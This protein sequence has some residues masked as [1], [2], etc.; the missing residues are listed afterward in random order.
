MRSSADCCATWRLRRPHRRK[1]SA[2]SEPPRRCSRS[3]SPLTDLVSTPDRALPKIAGIGPAS[4]RVILEVLETG[5]SATVEQAVAAS[6]RERRHPAAPRL[7]RQ[8]PE[9]GGG[10]ADPRRSRRSTGP[11]L[12]DYRGDLQMHSEWSD[13]VPA[14]GEIVEACLGARLFLRRRHRPF[15]WLEDRRRDVDGRGGRA[16]RA[17]DR[18]N[19]RPTASGSA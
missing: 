8:L 19:A 3:S 7:A 16:A 12:A 2:T 14:L 10:A 9:P 15:A 4:T 1:C 6:G 13:G 5:A 18:L 17:I 11:P